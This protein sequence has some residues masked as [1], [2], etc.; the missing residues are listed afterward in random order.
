MRSFIDLG[1]KVTFIP[2]NLLYIDCY[3]RDLQQMGVEC[4]YGPYS[5]TINHY[6][7]ANGKEFNVVMLYRVHTASKY[8]NDVNRYCPQAKIIFDTVD[9]HFLREQRE[10][11]LLNSIDLKEQAEK[12]KAAELGLIRQADITIVLSDAEIQ[13]LHTY[14][15]SLKLFNIPLLL[16]IFG[17]RKN[18]R[19]RSDIVFIGGYQHTPNI[20]AVEYF[21]NEVWPLIVDKLPEARFLIIGSKMP[22]RLAALSKHQRVIPIG[23]V[24]DIST[25]LDSCKL[26]VAPLRFGAGIKGK[27][28][29]SGSYGVPTVATTLAAEGMG[30]TDGKDVLLADTADDFAEQIIRLYKQEEI[31]DHISQNILEFVSGIC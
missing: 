2:E 30:L 6:L 14:D 15:S 10:A 11:E 9:L 12:T 5:R 24:P 29:S 31:W 19:E 23:F 22:E 7:E 21:V 18:F 1:Y 13:L 25:Y 3:T 20:D 8:V 16:E 28:G 4:I 27:I 26:T 17:K